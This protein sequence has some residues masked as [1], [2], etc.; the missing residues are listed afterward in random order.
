MGILVAADVLQVPFDRGASNQISNM[1]EEIVVWLSWARLI[2]FGYV[3]DRREAVAGERDGSVSYVISRTQ[4]VDGFDHTVNSTELRA[5]RVNVIGISRSAVDKAILCLHRAVE[6]WVKSK[7]SSTE[8]VLKRSV[9]HRDSGSVAN[10]H[11]KILHRGWMRN[12]LR[13]PLF[14][15]C[16]SVVDRRYACIREE[17]AER[18]HG[19][20]YGIKRE[21]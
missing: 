17:V 19:S 9:R 3:H 13:T 12:D 20:W 14:R 10:T 4:I 1:G 2:S 16:G 5:V 7:G 11:E 6:S 8:A 15:R 21:G 18:M